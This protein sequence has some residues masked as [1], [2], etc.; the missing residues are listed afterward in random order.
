MTSTLAAHRFTLDE[1]HALDWLHH[2]CMAPMDSEEPRAGGGQP[3]PGSELP[4][5]DDDWNPAGPG[6]E[7]EAYQLV[8]GA[9]EA[10]VIRRPAAPPYPGQ[11]AESPADDWDLDLEWSSNEDG[12]YY[13][14]TI[15]AGL[16]LQLVTSSEELRKLGERDARGA[17]AALAIL[18]E[19]VASANRALDALD[20]YVAAQLAGGGQAGAEGS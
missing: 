13:W 18:R 17:A 8:R 5:I 7:S 10:G 6:R 12:A 4:E 15:G 11:P 19:A 14:F 1:G 16:H 2:A 9:V 3:W 20:K